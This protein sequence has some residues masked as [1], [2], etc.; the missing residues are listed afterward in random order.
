MVYVLESVSYYPTERL[1]DRIWNTVYGPN[2]ERLREVSK[3]D[4]RLLTSGFSHVGVEGQFFLLD[5]GSSLIGVLDI[6]RFSKSEHPLV[7]VTLF[8]DR[9]FW[10][11]YHTV[12]DINDDNL[13]H[14]YTIDEDR[15]NW[16]LHCKPKE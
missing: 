1:L 11:H 12:Q 8:S 3:K 16:S 4:T 9:A 10:P 13:A 15:S 2:R 14:I 5:D 6:N 7:N